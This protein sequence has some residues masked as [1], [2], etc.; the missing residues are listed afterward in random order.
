MYRAVLVK[1]VGM[2]LGIYCY[3][4]RILGGEGGVTASRYIL[5]H[6]ILDDPG[7]NRLPTILFPFF[8]S[9][10]RKEQRK[11]A[12]P[13]CRSWAQRRETGNAA[14]RIMRRSISNRHC[15][16]NGVPACFA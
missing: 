3:I 13:E 9:A 2:E 4:A 10:E 16:N 12:P 14:T 6:G 11:T 1:S 15:S 7:C 5:L 8:L